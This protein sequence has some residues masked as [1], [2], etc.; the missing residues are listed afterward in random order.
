[1]Y[2]LFQDAIGFVKGGRNLRD[3]RGDAGEQAAPKRGERL[4]TRLQQQ[5]GPVAGFQAGP[6]QAA[7]DRFGFGEQLGE[8]LDFR[9]SAVSE[10]HDGSA[11]ID[12]SGPPQHFRKR[13]GQIQE[14]RHS[15]RVAERWRRQS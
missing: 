11:V 10:V 6:P 14:A 12:L 1:M 3:H 15:F 9:V 4:R 2:Q 5:N 7:A 13:P 8:R